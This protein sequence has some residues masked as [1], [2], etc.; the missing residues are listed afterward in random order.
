MWPDGV[1]AG[2]LAEVRDGV[3]DC[4]GG[5]GEELVARELRPVL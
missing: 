2:G 1:G 5:H 3:D 4:L